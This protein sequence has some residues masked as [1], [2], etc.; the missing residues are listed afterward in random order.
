MP[1]YSYRARNTNGKLVE[2]IL[3]A[4]SE[5]RAMALL[6]SNN[7]TPVALTP[8]DDVHFWQRDIGGIVTKK[9]LILFC[10][11]TAS[12]IHAGVPIIETL[13]AIEQQV[14]KR[15][16]SKTIREIAFM[17]ESGDSLSGAMNK[18]PHVFSPFI[19]GIVRTGEASGRLSDSLASVADYLEQD[20]VFIR[21]VQ[22]AFTYPIF[23][24]ILV[25]LLA[26]IMFTYVLPQLVQLFEESGVTLPLPTRIV[27]AATQFLS[28][29]WIAVIVF[30]VII[31]LLAR[32]YL[33]T[34][35]GRYTA[36]SYLLRIP[37]ISSFFMKFYLARLTSVLHTLFSS[38]VPT[39]DA[40]ALA[41]DAVGN[42]VYQRI[43][44]RTIQMIKD[45]ASISSVW[46]Q[47]PFIPPMLTSMVRVGERSGEVE[48]AFSEANRFFKRDVSAMLDNI[49]VLIEPI[50]LLILGV[51][52]GIVV[53]A[54]LLPIYNLVLV[55]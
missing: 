32:S 5:E 14:T 43:L 33:K 2:G 52:V 12:M 35:E 21:K 38:D 40:L 26:F 45:G 28:H 16:F 20:Y 13:K 7:L 54:V 6:T 3:R 41:K 29:Y 39:L 9:D 42:K 4:N 34:P 46:K 24:L 18:Y 11:Q 49:A 47:E 55:L 25:V 17:V 48:R 51:G 30:A 19:L 36:S 27:I 31:V 44:D 15:G 10:R 8:L 37:V 50:L 22:A 23:V 1:K 53:A